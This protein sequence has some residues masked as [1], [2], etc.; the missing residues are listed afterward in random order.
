MLVNYRVKAYQGC[1][2]ALE[3]LKLLQG[4][5]ANAADNL[6]TGQASSCTPCTH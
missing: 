2:G 6:L 1:Q 4:T 3:A 5:D